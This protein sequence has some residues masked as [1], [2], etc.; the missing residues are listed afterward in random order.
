MSS[1][2]ILFTIFCKISIL[3]GWIVHSIGDSK[4]SLNPTCCMIENYTKGT[5]KGFT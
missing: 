2:K 1:T 5:M 3:V 4:S